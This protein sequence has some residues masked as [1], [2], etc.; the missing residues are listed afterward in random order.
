M[1]SMSPQARSYCARFLERTSRPSLSS[2]WRTRA[3][4]WSP[5][6]TISDGSTSLR[7]L[8]S[9]DGITPSDLKPMSRSTSSLSTFTTVPVTMSPSSNSTIVPLM[10]SSKLMP[11]RSSLVTWRGVYSPASSNV[12]MEESVPV[13]VEGSD[14]GG[15]VSSAVRTAPTVGASPQGYVTFGGRRPTAALA[16]RWSAGGGCRRRASPT[17]CARRRDRPGRRAAAAREA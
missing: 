9:R 7:M 10:A 13:M 1:R 11:S 12:P 14:I 5:S 2:F 16:A 3:S 4:I 6:E 17:R 15:S 8:S